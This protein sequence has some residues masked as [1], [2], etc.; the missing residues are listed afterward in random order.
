MNQFQVNKTSRSTCAELMTNSHDNDTII[1]EST[2]LDGAPLEK[3]NGSAVADTG[4][5]VSFGGRE[6]NMFNDI[7]YS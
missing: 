1:L 3:R 2:L 5:N 7:W 6:K 4:K